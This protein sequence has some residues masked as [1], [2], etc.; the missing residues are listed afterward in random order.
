MAGKLYPALSDAP[1]MFRRIRFYDNRGEY[2]Y[3]GRI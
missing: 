2:F 3:K 1:E